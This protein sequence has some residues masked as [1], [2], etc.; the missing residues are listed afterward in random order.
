MSLSVNFGEFA[1]T[2]TDTL[3]S[4]PP[5]PQNPT[6]VKDDAHESSDQSWVLRS[7]FTDRSSSIN[8]QWIPYP[9]RDSSA[10]NRCRSVAAANL[11]EHFAHGIRTRRSR[12]T[13]TSASCVGSIPVA[14]IGSVACIILAPKTLLP[15]SHDQIKAAKNDLTHLPAQAWCKVIRPCLLDLIAALSPARRRA[16]LS[17]QA[18]LA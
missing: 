4:P 10:R 15:F 9:P 18:P 6:R 5:A 8:G 1:D 2:K 11:L 13:T 12:S 3:T 7:P 17:P 14:V 16:A